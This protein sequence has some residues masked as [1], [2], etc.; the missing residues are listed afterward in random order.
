MSIINKLMYKSLLTAG[1]FVEKSF[2]KQTKNPLE[3]NSKIL[4][5]TLKDNMYT[6]IGKKYNFK[7]IN[8]IKDFKKTFL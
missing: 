4:F 6:E 1:I 2:I 3:V 5:K 8:S 7:N